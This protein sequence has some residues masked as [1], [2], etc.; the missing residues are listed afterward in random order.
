VLNSDSTDVLDYETDPNVKAVVVGGNRLSRGLTLEGLLVS[1]YVRRTEQFDTLMQMGRWFGYRE[2]YVDLTRIWTTEELSG[3]FRD[4]ALAEEELRREIARYERENLTPLDFGPR[5]RSHPA[6]MI[7]AQDKMGSA[8]T[9]SQNYSGYMLQTTAFRLES[10]P[11]LQSNLDAAH[12]LFADLGN[13][14]H[15]ESSDTQ[16]AWANVPWQTVD[17][18]L[19]RYRFDPRG[20]HEMGA[21]RQY[22]Q[23]QVRQDELVEW[24]IAMPALTTPDNRLGTEPLLSVRGLP[25]SRISRTRLLNKPY[26]IGTLINPATLDGPPHSGDEEIG[27]S[28]EQLTAARA[29]ALADTDVRGRFPRALRRQRDA[30]QGLLLLYPISPESRPR[31]GTE[32]R[33]PL[34]DDPA[35]DGLTVLGIALVFPSSDSAATIEYVVGSVGSPQGDDE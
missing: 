16:P 35:R 34:F 29:E 5:I 10:R 20:S 25:A 33:L 4:L 15:P 8:R 24:L 21:I 7:T 23:A 17:A 9:V 19:S 1:F 18:F 31:A 3:W 14:N 30:R 12:Q 6:M 27:L 28:D 13:P 26:D 11:W 2:Q 22:L 32:T